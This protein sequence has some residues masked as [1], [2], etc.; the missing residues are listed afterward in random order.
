MKQKV[1]FF[2]NDDVGI[3]STEPIATELIDLTNLFID[4]G[5]PICHSVVPARVT[6]ETVSWLREMK[7]LHPR[8]ISI[9]QH[10]FKHVK[11]DRGEFGGKRSYHEQRPEITEGLAMMK[12]FFGADF[13]RWFAAPWVAYNRHTK[14]ICDELGFKIF[15]GGVSPR[16]YAR[17][18]NAAG[19][20]LNV[21]NISRKEVSYHRRNNFYQK[22]FNIREVSVSVDMVSDFT[23]RRVKPL[24]SIFDRFKSSKKYFDVI[25]ILLHHWVFNTQ[26]KIDFVKGLL[27]ELQKDPNISFCLIE[28]IKTQ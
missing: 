17:I 1:V 21:N 4:R 5:I 3:H 12:K 11:H 18:F 14:E 26:E 8:L 23:S 16:L 25:G 27:T 22:G 10:G 24:G 2:R 19:R 6:K 13:N 9:G 20:I 15:S 28:N 7:N